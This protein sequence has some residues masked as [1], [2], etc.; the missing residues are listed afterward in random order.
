MKQLDKYTFAGVIPIVTNLFFQFA[1][2]VSLLF[3]AGLIFK[4]EYVR[5][6]EKYIINSNELT[7]ETGIFKKTCT[8]TD[9][10][11]VAQ[12]SIEQ[13]IMGRLFKY[14]DLNIET[15]GTP[16]VLKNISKPGLIKERL[17]ELKRMSE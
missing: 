6:R 13:G 11:R 4:A 10:N 15:W 1:L 17:N 5:A 16:I 7:H 8:T 9:I 14:G 12:F 2:P 3:S